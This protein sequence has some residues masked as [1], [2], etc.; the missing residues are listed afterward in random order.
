MSTVLCPASWY[1]CR[2]T[3]IVSWLDDITIIPVYSIKTRCS[4]D[5]DCRVKSEAP[6]SFTI[7]SFFGLI[8]WGL[9]QLC[10]CLSWS[11]CPRY[12]CSQLIPWAC[13]VWGLIFALMFHLFISLCRLSQAEDYGREMP[14][15]VQISNISNGNGWGEGRSEPQPTSQHGSWWLHCVRIIVCHCVTLVTHNVV[16]RRKYPSLLSLPNTTN[17]PPKIKYTT[18]AKRSTTLPP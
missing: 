12:Q 5:A 9:C 3:S 13:D 17:S 8:A 14:W 1:D 18:F 15:V 11:S 7:L 6:H 10:K 4:L 2:V 16:F